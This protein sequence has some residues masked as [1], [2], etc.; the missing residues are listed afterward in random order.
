MH[1]SMMA[2]SAMNTKLMGV[3]L[4]FGD[5]FILMLMCCGNLL[6]SWNDIS[7]IIDLCMAMLCC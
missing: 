3:E 1:I 6:T 4:S 2:K 7:L 5:S